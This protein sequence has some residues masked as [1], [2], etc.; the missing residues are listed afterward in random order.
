MTEKQGLELVERYFGGIPRAKTAKIDIVKPMFD[1][2]TKTFKKKKKT[3]QTHLIVGFPGKAY[4]VSTRYAESL[5]SAILGGGMS[6]R[7]FLEVRERRGLAYAVKPVTD[8]AVD[9]GYFGAYS[10]TKPEKSAECREVILDQFYG[11]ASGKYPIID[12]ELIKAKEFVKGHLALSL[13]DTEDLCGFYAI[14]ELYTGKL[15]TPAEVYSAIDKVT[16][17]QVTSLAKELFVEGRVFTAS[18]SPK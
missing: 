3:D 18:I 1:A 11:L 14:E 13:E 5:L 17:E 12:K 15:R 8:H 4:G 10:G 9:V 16:S 6:S 2:E 7:L